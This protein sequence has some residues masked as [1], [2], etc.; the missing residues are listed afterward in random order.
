MAAVLIDTH[1]GYVAYEGAIPRY[2]G[3][4]RQQKRWKHT[5]SGCSHSTRLNDLKMTGVELRVE[6]QF[7]FPSKEEA[8]NWEINQI[9]LHGLLLDGT[10]T[11]FNSSAGGGGVGIK[12]SSGFPKYRPKRL[13]LPPRGHR[14]FIHRVTNE[15]RLLV[16][17]L[18]G[19]PKY[20]SDN[21]KDL[22]K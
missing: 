6:H 7:V 9:K 17:G 18:E 2:V 10:G 5:I 21:W 1:Y 11:L 13:P 12:G 14:W 8:Q 19:K 15:V 22:A 3:I 20:Q 4:S 16:V